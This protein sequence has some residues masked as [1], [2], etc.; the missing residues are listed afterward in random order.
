MGLFDWLKKGDKEHPILAEHTEN[1]AITEDEPTSMQNVSHKRLTSA[2]I[3]MAGFFSTEGYPENNGGM[4]F[5]HI[6]LPSDYEYLMMVT[7]VVRNAPELAEE[8]L[9]KVLHSEDDFA[10]SKTNWL[11]CIPIALLLSDENSLSIIIRRLPEIAP[12]ETT[13]NTGYSHMRKDQYLSLIYE[14]SPF[15]QERMKSIGASSEG[16]M[17]EKLCQLQQFVIPRRDWI[18]IPETD[19]AML[20]RDIGWD[21]ETLQ[22]I[23][24]EQACNWS[25][26]YPFADIDIFAEA[27]RRNQEKALSLIPVIKEQTDIMPNFNRASASQLVLPAWV[28]FLYRYCNLGEQ[29]IDITLAHHKGKKIASLCEELRASAAEKPEFILSDDNKIQKQQ[30]FELFCSNK[31]FSG[32]EWKVKFNGLN[33]LIWCGE[34]AGDFLYANACYA[35]T[36]DE[37]SVIDDDVI[38]LFNPVESGKHEAKKWDKLLRERQI[39]QPFK[40]WAMVA[41]DFLPEEVDSNGRIMRWQGNVAKQQS[42]VVVSGRYY[43]MREHDPGNSFSAYHIINP[44]D[45]IGA[46]IRFNRVWSG[47]EYASVTHK[48]Y[49]A[50]FYR[51]PGNGFVYKTGVPS[52]KTLIPSDVP[53]RFRSYVTFVFDSLAKNESE[54]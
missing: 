1:T 34:K 18:G 10:G 13:A 25:N 17:T 4:T 8:I 35:A 38:K 7:D 39:K 15:L 36:G 44:Y 2:E 51:L 27:V 47:P 21:D 22:K 45:N 24:I 40:Q 30:L 12:S 32:A 46:M 33:G 26:L 49:Y 16:N 3:L 29:V 48:I 50:Q 9:S 28:D 5:R 43:L 6:G 20:L 31:T 41:N 37:I 42:M 53:P 14:R 11:A 54:I 19:S 23:Y 52:S